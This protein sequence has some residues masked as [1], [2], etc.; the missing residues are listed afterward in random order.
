MNSD[1][2]VTAAGRA[3][4]GDLPVFE[5]LAHYFQRRSF[6]LGQLI[7]KEDAVVREAY[8][9]WIWECAAAEQPNVADGVMRRAEWSRGNEGSFAVEQTGDAMNLRRLN[10]FLERKRRND[11]R[12]AF[13]KHRFTRAGRPDHQI[14]CDRRPRPLQSRA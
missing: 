13:R 3:R 11:G 7:E 2:N 1:G 9:T 5:R 12:D 6:E 8:F 4:N 14:R 10:R